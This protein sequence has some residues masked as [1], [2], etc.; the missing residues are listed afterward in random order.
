MFMRPPLG[1]AWEV[2]AGDFLQRQEAVALGT[3]VDE[4]SF[5]AGLDAGDA[6]FVDVGFLLLAGTVLDVQ[7]V[8]RW[9]STRAHAQLF[10]Y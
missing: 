9:P 6:A 5:E 3:E 8:Q 2:L 10:F 7:V 1:R 4:G